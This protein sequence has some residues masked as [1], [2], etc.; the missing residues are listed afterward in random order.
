MD[1]FGPISEIL[2]VSNEEFERLRVGLS[3]GLIDASSSVTQLR[4]AG[5]LMHADAVHAWLKAARE[6][7][8]TTPALLAAVRLI[9]DER[10]RAA[11]SALTAELIL[12]GP[13]VEGAEARETRV[14][15]RE[16]F[17][18]AR[19]TVLIVGYAFHG[20]D[21]IFEPL[22]R[23]MARNAALRVRLVV[24]VHF[25]RG[26]SAEETVRSFARD[27]LEVS[28]PFEPRPDFYYDPSSLE[29]FGAERSVV[30]AK[31]IVVDDEILYLGSANFTTA[32]FERNVEAG[33]R[34]KSS[35]LGKKAADFF[36]QL[37]RRG[38]LVL[39]PIE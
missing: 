31:L 2:G 36:D 6:V 15:V 21:H 18:A 14:V 1:D 32:A 39:L 27:F 12:T 13:E 5:M 17:E 22:A 9:Q 38:D 28:W 25:D 10:H 24:N 8:A 4:R 23:R 16:L 29:K 19:R 30:H 35:T 37:I 11:R 34:V 20:S 33:V 7:F 3:Q 26:R